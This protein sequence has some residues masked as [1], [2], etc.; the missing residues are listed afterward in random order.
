MGIREWG[1]L[2]QSG[3]VQVGVRFVVLSAE[4]RSWEFIAGTEI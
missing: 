3:L 1:S 2:A 4:V